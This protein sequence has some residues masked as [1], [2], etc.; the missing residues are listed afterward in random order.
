MNVNFPFHFDGTGGTADPSADYLN[1]LVERSSHLTGR[2][3][4]SARLW[5]R[6][7]ANGL[8]ADEP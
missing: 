1:Q 2:T 4:Q 7:I 8:L 5:K 6:P 3:R